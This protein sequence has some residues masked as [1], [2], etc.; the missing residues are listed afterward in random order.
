MPSLSHARE[1]V[2]LRHNLLTQVT[3]SFW[4]CLSVAIIVWLYPPASP[5]ATLHVT[6][7]VLAAVLFGFAGAAHQLY[8]THWRCRPVRDEAKTVFICWA[9]AVAPLLALGFGAKM[10]SQFSRV[11]TLSWIL[12][13]PTLIVLLRVLARVCTRPRLRRTALAGVSKFSE[14]VYNTIQS[15]PALGLTVVG[16]FDD[17]AAARHGEHSEAF[18]RTDTFAQLL[19]AAHAGLIDVVYIALPLRAE[20]RVQA[21]VRE[22]QDSTVSVYI[23]FDFVSLGGGGYRQISYVGRLPVVPLLAG[24]RPSIRKQALT[25]VHAMRRGFPPTQAMRKQTGLARLEHRPAPALGQAKR[26]VSSARQDRP[27]AI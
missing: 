21:L 2:G 23:M 14:Q 8:L 12:L 1:P 22:L 19:A 25:L 11:A 16:V 27:N 9:W 3:D 5:S 7:A 6:V 18:T 13:T 4:I 24:V 26:S 10:L 17:R 20:R 15:T